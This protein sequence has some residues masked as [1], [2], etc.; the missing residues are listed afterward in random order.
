MHVAA[1]PAPVLSLN[2][3]DTL[4]AI[5]LLNKTSSWLKDTFILG[6]VRGKMSTK[7]VVVCVTVMPNCLA[8]SP[9]QK[10][11]PV[12]AVQTLHLKELLEYPNSH[13][14][15]EQRDYPASPDT[16]MGQKNQAG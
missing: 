5:N 13:R 8:Q 11:T 12:S 10:T 6:A 14:Y 16:W 2:Y 4:G 15:L 7:S 3:Q 9:Q 1:P